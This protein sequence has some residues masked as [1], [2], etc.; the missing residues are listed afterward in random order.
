[1]PEL[2]IYA[3]TVQE[4]VVGSRGFP[5]VT[6]KIIGESYAQ[7]QVAIELPATHPPV[8]NASDSTLG[9]P[10]VTLGRWCPTRDLLALVVR[11]TLGNDE[12]QLWRLNGTQIWTANIHYTF[13]QS[14]ATSSGIGNSDTHGR[15][16]VTALCWRPDGHGLVLA[17]SSGHMCVIDAETGA[18]AEPLDMASFPRADTQAPAAGVPGLGQPGVVVTLEWYQPTSLTGRMESADG[19]SLLQHMPRPHIPSGL[20]RT[21]AFPSLSEPSPFANPFRASTGTPAAVSVVVAITNCLTV[22]LCAYGQFPLA[23]LSILSGGT[24]P[25]TLGASPTVSCPPDLS[26]LVVGTTNL[27]P[28]ERGSMESITLMVVDLGWLSQCPN[29]IQFLASQAAAHQLGRFMRDLADATHHVYT[30]HLQ[31]VH[32][33]WSKYLDSA[34]ASHAST[35]TPR[36]ELVTLLATGRPS[37]AM[38][39]VL[40]STLKATG[41]RKWAKAVENGITEIRS[42]LLQSLKPCCDTLLV[43]LTEMRGQSQSFLTPN[44]LTLSQLLIVECMVVVGWLASQ[45]EEMLGF[46]DAEWERFQAFYTWLVG[47]NDY[48]T[49]PVPDDDAGDMAA[50][51]R[52][53]QVDTSLIIDYIENTLFD[54][55]YDTR[56]SQW[57]QPVPDAATDTLTFFSQLIQASSKLDLAGTSATATEQSPANTVMLPFVFTT[58]R[59]P[60]VHLSSLAQRTRQVLTVDPTAIPSISSA[61]DY[62]LDSLNRLL[63]EPAKAIAQAVCVTQCVTIPIKPHSSASAANSDNSVKPPCLIAHNCTLDTDGALHQFL[64]FPPPHQHPM[65]SGCLVELALPHAAKGSVLTHSSPSIRHY[66]VAAA[67]RA[68]LDSRPS[69]Q[70]CWEISQYAPYQPTSGVLLGRGWPQLPTGQCPSKPVGALLQVDWDSILLHPQVAELTPANFKSDSAAAAA[71]HQPNWFKCDA[72]DLVPKSSSP[73]AYGDQ[74]PVVRIRQLK[75]AMVGW[76]VVNAARSVVGIISRNGRRVQILEIDDIEPTSEEDESDN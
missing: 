52:L 76:L 66:P 65:A 12:V 11:N 31:S 69:E 54:P 3:P 39:Q 55:S 45:T 71:V 70:W 35:L 18:C 24:I 27:P 36:A 1:M 75:R 43:M 10:R 72:L 15:H 17:T 32:A 41:L 19:W 63:G 21:P 68:H 7:A 9:A 48:L 64:Y 28:R 44:G 20:K 60:Y 47:V 16:Q 73:I 58:P 74:L 25:T 6:D 23:Q 8:D 37:P 30:T 26:H 2:S 62:L 46:L 67:T 51:P 57:F 22:Y 5:L 53:P 14:N 33:I 4:Y 50:R 42:H 49:S 38:L 13:E 56:F 40:E 29:H 59:L 34:L 61:V